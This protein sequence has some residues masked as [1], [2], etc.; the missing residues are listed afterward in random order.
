MT[1]KL[2]IAEEQA[3]K[4]GNLGVVVRVDYGGS[5][6]SDYGRRRFTG[7]VIG[8]RESKVSGLIFR[9]EL[10]GSKDIVC[11]KWI[12]AEYCTPVFQ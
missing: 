8:Q 7:V 9:I 12:K 4:A 3:K 1:Y 2:R 5:I 10:P 6:V 11:A